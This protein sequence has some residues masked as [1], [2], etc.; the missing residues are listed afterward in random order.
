MLLENLGKYLSRKIERGRGLP[1]AAWAGITALSNRAVNTNPTS[2]MSQPFYEPFRN[3][4]I[5]FEK[6]KICISPC[7]CFRLG[8][9][10][11][12]CCYPSAT[13]PLPTNLFGF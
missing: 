8:S 13:P 6:L 12:K 1:P 4:L 7:F 10:L 3:S 9:F 5:D 2:K 11:S